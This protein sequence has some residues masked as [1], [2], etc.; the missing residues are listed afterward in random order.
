MAF[1]DEWQE[2]TEEQQVLPSSPTAVERRRRRR[3]TRPAVPWWLIAVGL[4]VV[5]LA[6]VLLWTWALKAMEETKEP[7]T[8]AITPTFTPPTATDTPL[9]TA[10][11]TAPPP[12]DTPAPVTPTITAQIA[13]GGWVKVTGTGD[14][15]L[16][17]RAG[18]GQENA[19]LKVIADGAI[20]KVLDGPR[21]DGGFTWWRLE[22]YLDG[23]PGVIGWAAD[24]F[25]QP[26]SAP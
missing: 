19:R 12:T 21:E 23:Q 2:P 9:P 6:I 25:L 14:L 10:S 15:G 26:T 17:F 3:R 8:I 13:I 7:P 22:E 1:N 20:L 24:T 11:P 16:S 5:V 18:P 4:L